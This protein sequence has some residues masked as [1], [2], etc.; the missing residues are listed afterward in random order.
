VK[1]LV[2]EVIKMISA[3]DLQYAILEGIRDYIQTKKIFLQSQLAILNGADGLTKNI[4]DPKVFGC[5]K[6]KRP[7]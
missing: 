6:A 7:L 5:V 4:N 3:Y 1:E 2:T